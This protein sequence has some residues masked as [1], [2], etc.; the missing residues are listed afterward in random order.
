[1]GRSAPKRRADQRPNAKPRTMRDPAVRESVVTNPD[2]PWTRTRTA[3][4]HRKKP[5]A[6]VF[7]ARTAGRRISTEDGAAAALD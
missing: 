7:P 3:S 2:Q 6:M 4:A 1:M 5:P